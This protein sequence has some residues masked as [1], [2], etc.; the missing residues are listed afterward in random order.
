MNYRKINFR[1]FC[2]NFFFVEIQQC[3]R[4]VVLYSLLTYLQMPATLFWHRPLTK[5][6]QAADYHP[7][8]FSIILIFTFPGRFNTVF[9]PLLAQ[10]L[11]SYVLS[12]TG[13]SCLACFSANFEFMSYMSTCPSCFKI[14]LLVLHTS[15]KLLF[16]L[17]CSFTFLFSF[18]TLS[19]HR[20]CICSR[21]S[22]HLCVYL[23]LNLEP[24]T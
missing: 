7:L 15:V 1:W 3:Q 13:F 11:R 5:I 19:C 24:V 4:F 17:Y 21:T 20:V 10:L 6:L 23:P 9:A 18:Y 16:I 22:I 2:C 8:L 12:L 14:Q